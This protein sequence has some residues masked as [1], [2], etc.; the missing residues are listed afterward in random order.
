LKEVSKDENTVVLEGSFVIMAEV[1]P[2]YTKAPSI[3]RE[4]MSVKITIT[5]VN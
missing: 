3:T 2:S 5:K 1:V 4:D